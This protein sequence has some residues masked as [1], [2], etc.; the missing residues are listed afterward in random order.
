MSDFEL[1]SQIQ[2]YLAALARG[3]KATPE[4]ES[5]WREFHR[6]HDPMIRALARR[7]ATAVVDAYDLTQEVWIMLSRDLL[8]LTLDPARGSLDALLATV[9]G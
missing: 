7:G 5:A 9:A 6:V 4:A 3:A 8:K 1:L 2:S